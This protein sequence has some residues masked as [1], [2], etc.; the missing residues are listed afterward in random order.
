VISAPNLVVIRDDMNTVIKKDNIGAR[1]HCSNAK[2]SEGRHRCGRNHERGLGQAGRRLLRRSAFVVVITAA[3]GPRDIH[4]HPQRPRILDQWLRAE[5]KDPL[6]PSNLPSPVNLRAIAQLQGT[7]TLRKA[8]RVE[9]L[10]CYGQRFS[11][12]YVDN[13]DGRWLLP[14]EPRPA[15]D[16][17]HCSLDLT[18]LSFELHSVELDQ[19]IWKAFT[20]HI[21]GPDIARTI[22]QICSLFVCGKYS[23][24]PTALKGKAEIF[25]PGSPK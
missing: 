21:F 5:G 2:L 11:S 14:N 18:S 4:A 13:A 1:S 22:E 7:K 8:T 17:Q 20:S 3:S 10:F 9:M 15:A 19:S 6:M 24:L 12:L 23:R 16:K 25:S